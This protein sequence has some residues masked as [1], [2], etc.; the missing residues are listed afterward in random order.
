[1]LEFIH[2]EDHAFQHEKFITAKQAVELERP[3]ELYLDSMYVIVLK[4]SFS[5]P[6]GR[7]W[8]MIVQVLRFHHTTV[9]RHISGEV[10]N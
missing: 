7:V 3:Y 10:N 5:V 4:P 8:W 9:D 1:M 2:V 6:R